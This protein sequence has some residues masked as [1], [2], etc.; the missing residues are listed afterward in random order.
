M[1]I[2][3][4]KWL[5][6]GLLG[7]LALIGFG[8]C[9]DD[10]FDIHSS[11]PTESL[12]EKIVANSKLDSLRQIL[13]RTTFTKDEFTKT[14]NL[15]YAQLL[16]SGQT[17]TVWAPEDGTYNAAKWLAMLDNGQNREVEKQFVRNHIARYNFSGISGEDT[18][19]VTMLNSK[20]NNYI[21]SENTFKNVPIDSET[22]SASNG[23][24][25]LLN[26][27]A[28]FTS[29]MYE[30]IEFTDNLDSLYEFFHED[31][32]LIFWREASTPGATVDGQIQYVDSVFSIANKVIGNLSLWQNEDSLLIGVFPNNNAWDE[33]ISKV[34]KYF[35]YKDSYA[36]VEDNT[37]KTLYNEFD[38]DS[39]ADVRIKNV[40]LNNVVTS[41][42]KQPGYDVSKSSLSYFKDFM[43]NADSIVRGGYTS[44]SDPNYYHPVIDSIFGGYEPFEVSNGFAYSIDH[45]GYVPSK[46]WH[47]T[48]R[49]EAEYQFYQDVNNFS[50]AEKNGNYYGYTVYLTSLNR[51]DSVVGTVSNNAFAYFPGSSSASQPTISFKI[52]S[53]LSGKYDIYAVMVPLFTNKRSPTEDDYKRNRFRATLT[54]DYNDRNGRAITENATNPEDGSTEFTTRAGV[55]DSVL[56]FSNFEFP[57]AFYGAEPSYPKLKLKSVVRTSAQKKEFSPALYVDCFL[58]VSKDDD[59]TTSTSDD[60]T[61]DQ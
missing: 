3:Y 36:Y 48:I 45:Y 14:S 12:W 56:L 19:K 51:N 28:P 52:P 18:I 27:Y 44:L 60:S 2:K 35:K 37:T 10:H 43:A 49:V 29:N 15:T 33:A 61:S 17:F 42:G 46:S 47:H 6:Y 16:S 39:M 57:Y 50:S 30:A 54:Y 22:E 4:C 8:A 13:E 21:L 24:L 53:I 40:I 32:T 31:D 34:S 25:H 55:V 38:P 7:T 58:F 11:T 23:S 41:L 20:V 26:G 59:D 5:K 1:N 9:S